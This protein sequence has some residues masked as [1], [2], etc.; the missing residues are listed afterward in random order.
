M[1]FLFEDR[2]F[3]QASQVDDIFLQSAEDCIRSAFLEA[4]LALA[5]SLDISRSSGT[6][7]LTALVFGR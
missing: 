4:D 5:D 7:A 6:T 1:R 2:E 3:P